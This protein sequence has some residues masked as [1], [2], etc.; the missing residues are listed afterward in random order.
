MR[1]WWIFIWNFLFSQWIF[2]FCFMGNFF[3]LFFWVS[4]KIQRN[5]INGYKKNVPQPTKKKIKLGFYVVIKWVSRSMNFFCCCK[6][7][8]LKARF[9]LPRFVDF[10]P[11]KLN[12]KRKQKKK[13]YKVTLTMCTNK[14]RIDDGTTWFISCCTVYIICWNIITHRL[15]RC[16]RC[17]ISI[18][19]W[20]TNF[21]WICAVTICDIREKEKKMKINES[22]M[23]TKSWL[24]HYLK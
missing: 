6:N 22:L 13:L 11:L 17:R 4:I 23:T 5:W 7:Y 2:F 8:K 9:E 15:L 14:V 20:I 10:I 3:G 1:R 21:I 12:P 24:S 18:R 19:A 16:Y